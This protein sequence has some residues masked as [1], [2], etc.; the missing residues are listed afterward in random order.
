MCYLRISSTVLNVSI[1]TLQFAPHPVYDEGKLFYGDGKHNNRGERS[2]SFQRSSS[3]VSGLTE[4]LIWGSN[5]AD[6]GCERGNLAGVAY[7]CFLSRL[8]EVMIDRSGNLM[9][10]P[11]EDL[12][13][14]YL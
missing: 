1:V 3:G 11:G 5:I 13:V 6:E 12:R 4:L 9:G 2:A 7:I 8:K 14:T 10:W